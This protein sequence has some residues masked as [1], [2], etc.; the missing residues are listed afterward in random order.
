MYSRAEPSD[1]F[2]K[3]CTYAYARSELEIAHAVPLDRPI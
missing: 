3:K 1:G 2:F